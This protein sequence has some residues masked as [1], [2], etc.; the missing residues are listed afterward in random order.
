MTQKPDSFL[1]VKSSD[2]IV[3]ELFNSSNIYE[4]YDQKLG[5]VGSDQ[6]SLIQYIQEIKK[7][8]KNFELEA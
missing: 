4:L 8:L 2:E 3:S 5:L 7:I 6:S 1:T